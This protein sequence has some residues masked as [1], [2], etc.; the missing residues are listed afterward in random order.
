MNGLEPSLSFKDLILRVAEL[1][2]VAAFSATTGAAEIPT[3]PHDLDKVKRSINEAQRLIATLNPQ[4]RRLR[5]RDIE[6]DVDVEATRHSVKG[7]TTRYWLPAGFT[8]ET[9]GQ[10]FWSIPGASTSG[11]A[12][13]AAD[14]VF[15][16]VQH[17]LDLARGLRGNPQ[18][19]AVEPF[20]V[21]P[22][23]R[24][25]HD[26][27][28]MI[29]YPTPSRPFT[30]KNKGR[31]FPVP[32]IELED[33]SLLGLPF[34]DALIKKAAACFH[35]GS[36]KVGQFEAEAAPAI[37]AAVEYDRRRG[38]RNVGEMGDPEASDERDRD[39]DRIPW[40]KRLGA[41]LIDSVQVS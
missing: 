34:D 36:E 9:F 21:Q 23:D 18:M 11:W 39:S 7:S 40:G 22:G 28:V 6:I 1:V 5:R 31:F 30:L 33:R 32:L 38:P 37:A 15:N 4:L 41:A 10:W 19:V 27:W 13:T 3:D 12:G 14:G 20:S 8:G 17:L 2:G 26:R 29:V 25:G 35:A 16:H 24:A